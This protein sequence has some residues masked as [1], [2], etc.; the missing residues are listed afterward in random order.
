MLFSCLQTHIPFIKGNNMTLK[1]AWYCLL[2]FTQQHHSSN[3]MQV[4]EEYETTL[5]ECLAMFT[6]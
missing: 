4:V 3:I 1:Y 2:I 5:R 6:T